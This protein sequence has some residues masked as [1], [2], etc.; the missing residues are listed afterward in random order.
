MDE[1]PGPA[2][3]Q[4][5]CP[6]LITQ[7]QFARLDEVEEQL[8]ALSDFTEDNHRN[9]ATELLQAMRLQVQQVCVHLN[10]FL[11][12]QILDLSRN[13]QRFVNQHG[14]LP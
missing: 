6:V 2:L 1:V 12:L 14:R 10:L 5:F 3:Q 13:I 11:S 9:P 7:G 8:I 4:L